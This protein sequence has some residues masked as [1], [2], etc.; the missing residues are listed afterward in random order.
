MPRFSPL[1]IA[2][3]V[4]DD[5][6][7]VADKL[8]Q[9]PYRWRLGF[10]RKYRQIFNKE[11]RQAANLYLLD[12]QEN[13]KQHPIGLGS[14]DDEIQ[15]AAKAKAR[16]YFERMAGRGDWR[17][18]YKEIS[19]EVVPLGVTPPALK[20]NSTYQSLCKRFADPIW[21]RRALRVAVNRHVEHEAIKA[22]MV[23][24]RAKYVSHET[25]Q[26]VQQQNRRNS[27]LLKLIEAEN[28]AGY[29]AT[30]AE[31]AEAGV[32]NP[33][34]RKHE[35][36]TRIRGI[37]EECNRKGFVCDFITITCPSKYHATRYLPAK[38]TR[39]ANPKYQGFSPR[40]GQ[41]YLVKVW[42]RV[43]AEFQRHGIKPVGF[44][45][46]EPHADG[47]PHWHMLLFIE[48]KKSG[49]MWRVIRK[50]ACKEDAFELV[51]KNAFEGRFDRK[52]IDPEQGSA[53]GYIA[54][55][56]A[57]NVSMTG[58]DDF[59]NDQGG[60]IT[61][62]LERAVSW[63][64]VWGIRQFQQQGGERITVWREL[65]RLRDA[66]DLPEAFKPLW[67][68]A[69]TGEYGQFLRQALKHKIEMLRA[70]DKAV[71]LYKVVY[72]PDEKGRF[73]DREWMQS[74]ELIDGLYNRY[75]EPAAGA[76]KGLLIDGVEVI[77]KLLKWTFSFKGQKQKRTFS[78]NK[79]T[80]YVE[81]G[82]NH[83]QKS[84]RT[85]EFFRAAFGGGFFYSGR[86]AP[87]PLGLV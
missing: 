13:I 5:R 15:A 45:V 69:D 42:S 85:A 27:Q 78:N 2:A 49:D 77:T 21:W 43:R 7:F 80:Q 30:L 48:R 38:K 12:Q 55:Y 86:A 67:R 44:R 18:L 70:T 10:A 63:S 65:R 6:Q 84:T 14:T 24:Q 33:E 54:K 83:R 28:D 53:A 25:L 62:A 32:S 50:H 58:I 39:I 60:S 51:T 37:E 74:G 76:I 17:V 4:F 19:A 41:Q 29:K 40:D 87:A 82:V 35:L 57:K 3:P 47:C 72:V 68:A 1:E 75:G 46:A 26:R 36:M 20:S 34:N 16:R 73:K 61:E 9:F 52:V 66:Q 31:L 22:G 81:T 23:G 64:R 79:L 56:I 59:D 8:A 71:P 11:G